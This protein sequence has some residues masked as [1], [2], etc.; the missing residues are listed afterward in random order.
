MKAL[1]CY[2][3]ERTSRVLRIEIGEAR[4]Q[5]ILENVLADFFC[6]NFS[7]RSEYTVLVFGVGVWIGCVSWR[8]MHG[9][10]EVGSC[11]AFGHLTT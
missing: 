11:C 3:T 2:I 7:W 1:R 8:D 6:L 5:Q 10:K 9:A 4:R